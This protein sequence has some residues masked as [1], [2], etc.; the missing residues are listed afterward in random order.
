MAMQ[1]DYRES[2][3][4]PTSPPQ[5]PAFL[6]IHRNTATN[7]FYEW[8]IG[9]QEWIA[10]PKV[11]RALLT[12]TGT[13]APVATVLENTLGGVPVWSYTNVGSYRLTLAGAFPTTK[14]IILPG[15]D[16]E[17]DG[18]YFMANAS[19]GNIVI[20]RTQDG[21]NNQSNDLMNNSSITILVYP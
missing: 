17:N 4:A 8:N 2:N 15:T 20:V 3:A 12:Q 10:K 16:A 14:T 9:L 6:A 18:W 11:Y 5:N 21:G 7:F 19:G 1:L 13:N